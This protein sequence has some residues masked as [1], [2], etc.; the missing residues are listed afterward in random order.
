MAFTIITQGT[1]TQGATAASQK[2][3]LPSSA[4]YF[5]VY[6][7]T[8]LGASNNGTGV[9]FEWFGPNYGAAATPAD[10]ALQWKI[11]GSNVT[12]V[13]SITSGGFTYVTTTP[14]VEAQASS[15]ITAITNANPAVVTQSNSYSNGDII[16][17]YNT[18]GM[19]QAG[20][21]DFQISS[22]SGSGYTLLGLP[23]TASNGFAAA[24]TAGNTRRISKNAAVDPEFL[25]VTNISQA[26]SA[27]VSTSV[28]PSNY[29]VVGMKVRF[30]VPSTFG[31]TQMD[32]LTGTI[33]AVNGVAASNNIGAYNFTVD[34]NSSGF[35]AFAFPAS[36]SSPT[37][38]LFATVAPAGAKTS[39]DPNTQV[40]TGYN[41]VTQPFHTG[42]FTP[43]M[44]LR[45]GA[46]SPAGQASDVILWQAYKMET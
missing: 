29:Y 42:Q 14:F 16:R 24:A 20:G 46:N 4:D 23:A 8:Q 17:I 5:K 33:T 7:I 31:M 36:T 32:G 9:I 3:I 6:N 38:R 27:V 19:L 45:S 37:S 15:A 1:F 18:T 44:F 22:V 21:M 2:I 12:N 43:Y 28:D 11:D 39:F 25:Y 30:S 40:Q 13:K 26:S 35:S 10:G 34:I 41:F